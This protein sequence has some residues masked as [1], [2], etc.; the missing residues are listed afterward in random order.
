MPNKI[1]PAKTDNITTKGWTSFVFPY[2]KGFIKYPSTAD[3][4]TKVITVFTNSVGL[5]TKAVIA[6]TT[7]VIIP[8]KYG[9]K[10]AIIAKNPNKIAFGWPII[11]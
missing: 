5:I 8:P 10:F 6:A 3:K 7:L 11:V 1:P 2:T 4:I 9:I